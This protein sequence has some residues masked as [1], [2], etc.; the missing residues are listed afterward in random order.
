MKVCSK[1]QKERDETEYYGKKGVCKKCRSRKAKTLYREKNPIFKKRGRQVPSLLNERYGL[2]VVMERVENSQDRKAQWLCKCD[3][4]GEKI[5]TS[6]HLRN[7]GVKSCGCLARWHN[8]GG[9]RGKR[10]RGYIL[11]YKPKHP[12]SVRGGY[13][14]EHVFVM[15]EYIG[16]PL[17]K[18]EQVHHRN[19][20]KSDNRIENLELWSGSHP[21]GQRVEDMIKFCIDYLREYKSELLLIA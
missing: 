20:I 16:R 12:N 6:S 8:R 11:I 17:K 19:G 5:T 4:G 18:K 7:G 3:C 21:T 1:C 10:E 2:L 15:S 14:R 9:K 13:I